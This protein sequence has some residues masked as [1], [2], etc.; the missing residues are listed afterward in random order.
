MAENRD[1]SCLVELKEK[2]LEYLINN[3]RDDGSWNG[4][5]SVAMSAVSLINFGYGGDRLDLAIKKILSSQNRDGGWNKEVFYIG[6]PDTTKLFYYSR[7]AS[8]A[9]S[10]EAL[11]KYKNTLKFSR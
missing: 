9:I 1:S 8:T 2:L 7:A 6:P 10:I 3:Q 11:L 4:P 5:L